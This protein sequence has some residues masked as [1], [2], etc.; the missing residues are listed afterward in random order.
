MKP[1]FASGKVGRLMVWNLKEERVIPAGLNKSPYLKSMCP[2]VCIPGGDAEW[3]TGNGIAGKMGCTG[4]CGPFGPTLHF[5][6][7]ILRPHPVVDS[8][9][10]YLRKLWNWISKEF[11]IWSQVLQRNSPPTAAHLHLIDTRQSENRIACKM[12]LL[13]W[14]DKKK[15]IIQLLKVTSLSSH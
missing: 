6:C 7:Y 2:F 11:P 9:E 4:L 14:L 3:L 1:F 8:L 5:I 12:G 15:L 10:P 13:H